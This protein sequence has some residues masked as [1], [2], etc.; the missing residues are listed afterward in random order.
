[1]LEQ[2]LV[3]L[4]WGQDNL[5]CLQELL[6]VHSGRSFGTVDMLAVVVCQSLCVKQ[7]FQRDLVVRPLPELIQQREVEKGEVVRTEDA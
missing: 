4:L 1:M 3:P 2:E 7:S 6:A 5:Q